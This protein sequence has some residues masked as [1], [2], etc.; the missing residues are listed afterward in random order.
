MIKR[1]F[2]VELTLDTAK[3]SI[4]MIFSQGYMSVGTQNHF[5]FLH[6]LLIGGF[7]DKNVFVK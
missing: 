5:Q 6:M 7:F 3:I 4:L 2:H 1:L